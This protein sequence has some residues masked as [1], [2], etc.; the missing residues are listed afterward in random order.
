[1]ALWPSAAAAVCVV[2]QATS[3]LAVDIVAQI[4]GTC[5]TPP[6]SRR[7]EKKFLRFL[8]VQLLSRPFCV[9]V[10]LCLLFS[11]P[12]R[13]SCKNARSESTLPNLHITSCFASGALARVLWGCTQHPQV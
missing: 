6:G 3:L 11:H 4:S 2:I 7:F 9:V 5:L 8:V 1:M 12:K 13:A 10:A